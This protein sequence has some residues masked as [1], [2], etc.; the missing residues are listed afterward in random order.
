MTPR[1]MVYRVLTAAVVVVY[2]LFGAGLA[3]SIAGFDAAPIL[4][5]AAL[6]L[7]VAPPAAMVAALVGF[8]AR[9]DRR[10]ASL[11]VLVFAVM[12]ASFLVGL[13]LKR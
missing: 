4:H 12:L 3:A 5:V 9:G 13:L 8:L 1:K 11:V 7:L 2:A 10:G 6:A